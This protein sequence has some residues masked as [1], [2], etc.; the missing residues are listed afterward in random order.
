MVGG[1]GGGSRLNRVHFSAFPA[2]EPSKRGEDARRVVSFRLPFFCS[3]LVANF[4]LPQLSGC[5]ADADAFG[6]LR[7]DLDA[8][9]FA[10]SAALRQGVKESGRSL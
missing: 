3:H 8:N 6:R 9:A 2:N 7:R 10:H 1:N 5:D 4:R